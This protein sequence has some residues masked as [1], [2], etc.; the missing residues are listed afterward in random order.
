[1]SKNKKL[2]YLDNLPR[3]GQLSPER[4]TTGT[5]E[6]SRTR[7]R[8]RRR[9]EHSLHCLTTQSEPAAAAQEPS[10][11]SS[12]SLVHKYTKSATTQHGP[13]NNKLHYP[14]SLNTALPVPRKATLLC[15][16]FSV[17]WPRQRHLSP[18]E[19]CGAWSCCFVKM[20]Q[21]GTLFTL[22]VLYGSKIAN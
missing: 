4:S 22:H 7:R 15:D 3:T 18:A 19:M 6:R 1:M 16:W 10:S 5:E 11:S 12:S 13:T 9:K 14:A 2:M 20:W 21:T 17:T 8:R